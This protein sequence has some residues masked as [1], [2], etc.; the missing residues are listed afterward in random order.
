MKYKITLVLGAGAS[1]AMGYPLGSGLR[2]E[3]INNAESYYSEIICGGSFECHEIQEFVK[4]FKNSQ[5]N[6]IDEFLAKRTEFGEI[7]KRAIASILLDMEDPDKLSDCDH[8]DHW[9]N[10]L[11]NKIVSGKQWNELDL[12]GIAIVT[13]NYDRSLEHYLAHAL[14]SA[15][16]VSTSHAFDKIAQINI[17]HIYGSLGSCDPSESDYF[18]YGDGKSNMAVNIAASRLKII[19]EGR[20]DDATLTTART[21]LISSERIAFLGFGFDKTNL[22]RLDSKNTCCEIIHENPSTKR[23]IVASAY[24]MTTAEQINAGKM[25]IRQDIERISDLRRNF[26]HNKC[27]MLLRETGILPDI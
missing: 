25:T 17:I 2:K 15:Y 11:F 16:G 4:E 6:S 8:E 18:S 9:Y 5:I 19:P 21:T 3:I 20:Q 7:G 13:F 1:V 27:L 26:E 12:S 24:G 14:I 10:Y 23:I 22:N